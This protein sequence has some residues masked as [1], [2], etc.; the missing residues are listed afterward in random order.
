M[1]LKLHKQPIDTS[2]FKIVSS[3]EDADKEDRAYYK[4]LTPGERLEIAE[5]LRSLTYDSDAPGLQRI[6]EV[7]QRK[8]D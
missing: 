4:S 5:H 6:F 3:F 8:R 7:T 1:N 2:S